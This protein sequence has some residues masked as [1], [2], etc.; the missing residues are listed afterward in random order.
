MRPNVTRDLRLSKLFIV[1]WGVIA[2]A[3]ASFAAM[4]DNL[5]QA[6]NIIGSLFY[7]TLLGMFVCGFF[8]RRVTALPVLLASLI[9]QAVVVF[10]FFESS[11]GFLWYNV[12]GTVIVVAV[13]LVLQAAGMGSREARTSG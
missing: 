6:V 9:S 8:V 3:F 11:I 12:I 1:V 2:I 7:G 5:I 4:L 10:L 13:A